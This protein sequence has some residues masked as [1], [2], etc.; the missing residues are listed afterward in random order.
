M[1]SNAVKTRRT[2]VRRGK[3]LS[4]GIT[5]H[6]IA[7]NDNFLFIIGRNAYDNFVVR[8]PAKALRQL[9]GLPRDHRWD[10]RVIDVDPQTTEYE[11]RGAYPDFLSDEEEEAAE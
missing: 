6:T 11:Y 3:V 7:A 4:R 10:P 1:P 5:P 8:V 9:L 2:H